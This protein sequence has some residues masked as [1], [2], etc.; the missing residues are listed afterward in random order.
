MRPLTSNR[1]LPLETSASPSLALARILQEFCW[2]ATDD[3]L[4]TIWSWRL[5]IVAFLECDKRDIQI[6]ATKGNIQSAATATS[7][8]AK[9]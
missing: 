2:S 9:S 3:S 1:L 8:P 4:L 7:P 6:C 5:L